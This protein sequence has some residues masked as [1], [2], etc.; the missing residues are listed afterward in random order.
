MWAATMLSRNRGDCPVT[1]GR[2][3]LG[4]SDCGNRISGAN[5][6]TVF[7]INYWSILLSFRDVATGRTT[8]ERRTDQR[9]QLSMS[10][11]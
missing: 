1:G 11:S 4:G 2:G 5:F 10:R 7:R 3:N 9:W 6:Y 8:D